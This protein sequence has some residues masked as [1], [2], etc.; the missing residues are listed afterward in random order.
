MRTLYV[1]TR[2]T[3]WSGSPSDGTLQLTRTLTVPDGGRM[4]V[5]NVRIPA[6]WNT[7]SLLNQN[8]YY[9]DNG[10]YRKA[11]IARGIYDSDSLA[12]AIQAAFSAAGGTAVTVAYSASTGATTFSINTPAA[13]W[14]LL[15]DQQLLSLAAQYPRPT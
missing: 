8:L 5:D 11:Q 10:V 4:R 15:T 9:L 3:L 6:I 2:S 12:A 13:N 7:V 14:T 1:D